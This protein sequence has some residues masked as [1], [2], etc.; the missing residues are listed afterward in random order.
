MDQDRFQADVVY[1]PF[2]VPQVGIAPATQACSDGVQ[3][4]APQRRRRPNLPV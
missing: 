3:V 2:D 1:E 4:L